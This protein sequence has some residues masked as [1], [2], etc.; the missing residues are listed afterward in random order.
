VLKSV[1]PAK[2]LITGKDIFM[3]TPSVTI[4]FVKRKTGSGNQ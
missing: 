1:Q 4:E 2:V 3:C